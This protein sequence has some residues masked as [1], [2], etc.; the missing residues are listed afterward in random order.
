MLTF[1]TNVF[2]KKASAKITLP[3]KI[4][5]V[6]Q[7][8]KIL[9]TFLF[10]L[11]TIS[12]ALIIL[13]WGDT[14]LSV[15]EDFVAFKYS[16]YA[17]LL[18]LPFFFTKIYLLF[19]DANYI[20][21]IKKV[22][23]VSVVDSKSSVR[24]SRENLYRKNEIHLAIED[25]KG[26]I[27]TKKVYEASS[28]FSANLEMYKVGDKVLHLHGTGITIVLPTAKDTHCCCCMCGCSNDKSNDSCVHCGLPLIKSI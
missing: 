26:R 15:P 5:K 10:V 23:I 20:G 2:Q 12:I 13:I 17:V 11:S 21:E 3:L 25:E 27:L 18:I 1:L 24:P 16:C 14:I 8:K 28:N 7:K 22:N 6:I 4:R 9:R 19:T